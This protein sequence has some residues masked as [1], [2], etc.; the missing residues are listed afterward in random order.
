MAF[1]IVSLFEASIWAGVYLM[2]GAIPGLEPA[3]VFSVVTFTTLGYGDT[4]LNASWRLLGSFEAATGVIMSGWSTALI[5]AFVQRVA[6]HD[7]A[8]AERLK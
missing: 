6:A 3:L 2:V 1:T 4:P 7:H 5:F 8:L